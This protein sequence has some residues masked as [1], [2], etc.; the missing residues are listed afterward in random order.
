MAQ[1]NVQA[2]SGDVETV[3]TVTATNLIRGVAEEAVRW[4]SQSETVF[5]QSATTRYY[6]IAT[7]GAFDNN[8]NGGKLR[9]SGTIGGF[10]ENSTTLIDAYVSSRSG[11][12]FGGTL[13][14]YGGDPTGVFDIVVYL[15]SDGT[16]GVWL[17]LLRFFTFDFTILGAQV[18]NNTRKL[19]V[20]PCPTTD[21]SVATPTGTLQGS[22]VD[23]CSV[24]FTDD[25]NV[26]ISSNVTAANSKFSLD[27]NGTLKQIGAG[28]NN[29]YIK[30]MK[31]FASGSNWKIA[32][33][34]YLGNAWQWLSIRA[35]MT[36]LNEDV[37]I[38]QFNY[39]GN[40]G[41]SRVRDSIVIGGG[42]AATQANEIK[43]YNRE[44][45]STYEIYLQIDSATS[46]EVEITHR[47]STIDD[48]YST[49]ATANNGAID[50]TGL[51]KIYDSGTTTDLRLKLGNVGIGITNPT[52]PLSV[53]A[54]GSTTLS[55]GSPATNGIY[56]T[57]N[58]NSANEDATMTMRVA[59]SSAGDPKL[60]WDIAG[61]AGFTMGMDN[62]DSDKFKLC[63]NWY[64]L[65]QGQFMEIDRLGNTIFDVGF[66]GGTILS[67]LFNYTETQ[68]AIDA[69]VGAGGTITASTDI[70]PPPG[71]A[72]DVIAKFVNQAGGEAY[73]NTWYPGVI[74]ISV[75]TVIYFG[76]WI[77]AT[78][79]IDMEFFRFHD[80]GSQSRSFSYTTPNKWVWFERTITSNRAYN[81][82]SFRFDNNSSGR[83][84]YLT[85]LTI[86]VGPSQNSGLPFTPRYSPASGKGAVFTTHNLV[87]KEAAI[88]TLTG[89]VDIGAGLT[90]YGGGG[91]LITKEGY[92][93]PGDIN[94]NISGVAGS[95]GGNYLFQGIYDAYRANGQ[96]GGTITSIFQRY[97]QVIRMGGLVLIR[98]YLPSRQNTSTDLNYRF[99]W[100]EL[101]LNGQR[102]GIHVVMNDSTSTYGSW[103]STI[104]SD[105]TYL[106]LTSTGQ[107][108]NQ[109]SVNYNHL[110][111]LL[112][113]SYIAASN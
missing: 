15:E 9:I 34:S 58:T 57:N 41:I 100:A 54:V 16:F 50:E 39:Y 94:F 48:D 88:K 42:G 33:G 85:G 52:A 49:V 3:G 101:G 104:G 64:D 109:A 19:A 63:G 77:Y 14:G 75:G 98:G 111:Y 53:L 38:I 105:A 7:L 24:V 62:S 102:S 31:Y 86:R 5:P 17:K 11:I 18:S 46:V 93:Q 81:F 4:N 96:T 95:L 60:S 2:F 90:G 68:Q 106:T 113:V 55:G 13:S 97:I 10:G 29:N 70:V 40:G 67:G 6:K 76:V 73:T 23:A 79:T 47:G 37:E 110:I 28:L 66:G 35:K 1:T 91:L 25:G 108:T 71:T 26:E 51:T 45:N 103:S 74:P 80:T 65:S 61:S 92:V 32:T 112:D 89:P 36:R 83:T 84:V 22:V 69:G 44:S 59:G 27:T 21:T 87:A 30:L 72:G 12:R 8:A 99:A 78:Q 43:V 82:S 107:T 56:L 20:L